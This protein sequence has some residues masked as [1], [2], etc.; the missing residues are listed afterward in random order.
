MNFDKFSNDYAQIYAETIKISGE[1]SDYFYKYKIN[2]LN[3][4]YSRHKIDSHIKLLD[5]GCGIG[6]MENY[7][8]SVFPGIEIYGIDTSEKSINTARERNK[9]I[10]FSVYNGKKIPFE[11][12]FFDA[13]LLSCVLHH[14]LPSDRGQILKE[15]QRVLKKSGY[16]FIFEHNPFSPLTRYVVK[17]CVFD[18]DAHLLTNW[19]CSNI[20]KKSGFFVKEAKYIVFF[21]KFLK[22]LRKFEEKLGVCPL[23]AQ[24]FIAAYKK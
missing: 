8:Y 6:Q 1:S 23:G 22:F 7:I 4:F 12:N 13:V 3:N 10:S 5:L 16:L 24:Y 15:V 20:I 2:I 21:P 17:T 9:G 19:N 18:K 14:I 11:D